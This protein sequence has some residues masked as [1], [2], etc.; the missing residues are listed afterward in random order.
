MNSLLIFAFLKST[1]EKFGVN[2]NRISSQVDFPLTSYLR[3]LSKP[4][5]VVTFAHNLFASSIHKLSEPS[6]T[7]DEKTSI[8]VKEDDS[9]VAVGILPVGKKCGLWENMRGMRCKMKSL[10]HKPAPHLKTT[11]HIVELMKVIKH[12]PS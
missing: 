2:C 6:N 4:H 9:R 7:S 10:Q 12:K 3:W 11:A 8:D 1:F 5:G